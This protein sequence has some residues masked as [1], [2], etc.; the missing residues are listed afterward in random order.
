MVVYGKTQSK[1]PVSRE[2]MGVLKRK[3][4]EIPKIEYRVFLN[5]LVVIILLSAIVWTEE[6]FFGI[7][8]LLYA[9]IPATTCCV[10]YFYWARH[11]VFG[12]FPREGTIVNLIEGEDFFKGLL[13]LKGYH[14]E[15]NDVKK[16]EVAGT[17]LPRWKD[18]WNSK[19]ILGM[20]PFLWPIHRVHYYIQ[21]WTKEEMDG[22]VTYVAEILSHVLVKRYMYTMIFP[23]NEDKKNMPVEIKMGIEVQLSNGYKPIFQ[24]QN[25]YVAMQKVIGGSLRHFV[26]QRGFNELIKREDKQPLEV[27]FFQKLEEAG[28]IK[29]LEDV[30]AARI[31]R[32]LIPQVNPDSKYREATTR[33]VVAEMNLRGAIIDAKAIAIKRGRELIGALMCMLQEQTGLSEEE[34]KTKIKE[35][36]SEF[37]KKHE[38]LFKVNLDLIQRQMALD[39]GGFIDIRVPEGSSNGGLLELV[40]LFQ[41]MAKSSPPEGQSAKSVTPAKNSGGSSLEEKKRK[42][43]ETRKLFDDLGRK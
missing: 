15:E 18:W 5:G 33:Q 9:L 17:P 32:I 26:S 14:L 7:S 36:P 27:E 1:V 4:A 10:Y 2:E 39:K 11:N 38:D 41:K 25:W 20:R 22:A 12:T 3:L 21:A 30:Y 24:S 35:G 19:N 42:R 40:A 34:L 43:E 31:T 16:N 6:F 13:S 29:S 23:D 28:T 37:F 8:L